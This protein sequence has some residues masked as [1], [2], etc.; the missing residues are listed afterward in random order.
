MGIVYLKTA[1]ENQTIVEESR[2]R[3][4]SAPFSYLHFVQSTDFWLL[5]DRVSLAPRR[6]Q[7]ADPPDQMALG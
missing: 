7:G 3:F 6:D 4:P 1:P 2:L 5:R